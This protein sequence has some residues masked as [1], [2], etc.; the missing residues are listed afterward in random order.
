MR[1]VGVGTRV[2]NFLVDTFFIFV[3]SYAA[4]KGWAFYA[5]YYG[6]IYL[7]FYYFFW[8]ILF[9]YYLLF[10]GIFN[11]TP[12]KWLSLTKVVNKNGM[13]PRFWQIVVRSLVRVTIID[14]FFL[15]F[16]DKTL[17]DYVSGT[18]VV[19]V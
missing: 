4:Y 1:K 3:L 7:P 9:L 5:F 14:C 13:K 11:R 2:L 10:E 19:E 17:H 6:I 18:E 16:L 8:V 15:P 12:G